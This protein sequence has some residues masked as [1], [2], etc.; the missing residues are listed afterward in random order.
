ML[1]SRVGRKDLHF[2]RI[3]RAFFVGQYGADEVK[4]ALSHP[5]QAVLP[6]FS[7]DAEPRLVLKYLRESRT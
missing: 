6:L 3:F 2:M 7:I 4:G 1:H 5:M